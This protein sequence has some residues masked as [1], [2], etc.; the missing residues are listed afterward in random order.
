MI[1]YVGWA[2]LAVAVLWGLLSLCVFVVERMIGH[3]RL[4]RLLTKAVYRQCEPPV[5]VPEPVEVNPYP[6]VT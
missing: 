2:T 4:L 1:E 6:D 3:I 5:E